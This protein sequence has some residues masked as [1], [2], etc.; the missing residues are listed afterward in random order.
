MAPTQQAK[1]ADSIRRQSL[2]GLVLAAGSSER[3]G[4]AKITEAELDGLAIGLHA[5]NHLAVHAEVF[6]VVRE[7]DSETQALFQEA[8]FETVPCSEAALGM[9]HSLA[10]GMRAI[11]ADTRTFRGCVV[12]L[13]DMPTVSSSTIKQICQAVNEPD[14]IVRPSYQK[15]AGHPVAFGC[16]YFAALSE[17]Q[18]DQGARDVVEKF[19]DQLISIEV[20]D[21]GVLLDVDRPGDLEQIVRHR[22]RT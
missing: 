13:G 18:G 1:D 22:L 15:K 16:A 11:M 20:D 4:G 2:A 7:G 3:F 6:V 8:G 10:C 21:P 12:A 17:L 14:S 5:A 9:G 19:K